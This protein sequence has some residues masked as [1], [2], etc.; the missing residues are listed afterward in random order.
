MTYFVVGYDLIDVGFFVPHFFF[1]LVQGRQ[2]VG[3]MLTKN[4]AMGTNQSLVFDA[5]NL[6]RFYMD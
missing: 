5:D 1:D 4:C 6:E 2:R 3:F